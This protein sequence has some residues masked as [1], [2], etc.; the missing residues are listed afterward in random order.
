MSAPVRVLSADVVRKVFPKALY[1][2]GV[3]DY[4]V[5]PNSPS[6]NP[7]R[8][9]MA[10]WVMFNTI[11]YTS[12]IALNKEYQYRL[13]AGDVDTYHLSI[14][15]A[16]TV[17]AWSGG[18]LIGN[19]VLKAKVWYFAVATYDGAKWRLY[20]NGKLDGEKSE[21]GDLAITT[22]NLLLGCYT[23]TGGYWF[24]GYI[25][26]VYIYARALSDS[27]I[28]QLYA[29]PLRPPLD[30]LILWLK[31]WPEFI[32]DGVWWDASGYNNHGTIYGATV[33]DV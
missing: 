30:G 24:N 10:M 25:A 32:H 4:V 17:T 7:K 20:L 2:D 33:V 5:I 19:T 18:T 23:P 11:P 1:F 29:H 12:Q 26:S 15:Y 31:G 27:E 6:L 14:R 22:N 9:T 3:N 16:T 13:I 21:S 8:I 28:Y